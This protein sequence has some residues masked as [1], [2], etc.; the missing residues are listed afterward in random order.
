MRRQEE[1]VS[2]AAPRVDQS[3][4]TSPLLGRE[5]HGFFGIALDKLRARASPRV[6]ISGQSAGGKGPPRGARAGHHPAG[7]RWDRV[8]IEPGPS[9]GPGGLQALTRDVTRVHISC[10]P[11]F[12]RRLEDEVPLLPRRRRYKATPRLYWMSGLI[13]PGIEGPRPSGFLFAWTV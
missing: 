5:P 13:H 11:S 6:P 1:G 10:G 3:C 4:K 8:E 2:A 7:L 9:Q 12:L